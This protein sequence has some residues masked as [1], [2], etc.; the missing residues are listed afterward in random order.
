MSRIHVAQWID[1]KAVLLSAGAERQR[2]EGREFPGDPSPMVV[3]FRF[4]SSE[5]LTPLNT[6]SSSNPR[7]IHLGGQINWMYSART[8]TDTAAE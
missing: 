2:R 6:S 8:W 3:T 7:L 4:S 1:L 5:R